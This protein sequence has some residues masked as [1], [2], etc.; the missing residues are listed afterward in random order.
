M[1]ELSHRQQTEMWRVWQQLASILFI[2]NSEFDCEQVIEMVLEDDHLEEL[3]DKADWS[4]FRRES[5][6][7]QIELAQTVFTANSYSRNN[8]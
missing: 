3:G 8:S 7:T 5:E 1:N 6:S 2:T 4:D